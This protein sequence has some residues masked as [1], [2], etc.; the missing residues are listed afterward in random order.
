VDGV[1]RMS[2]G[3]SAVA[4]RIAATNADGDD[5]PEIV[6]SGVTVVMDG[7]EDVRGLGR[8]PCAYGGDDM[9]AGWSVR[10]RGILRD[11]KLIADEVTVTSRTERRARPSRIRGWGYVSASAPGHVVVNGLDVATSR[12]PAKR[13]RAA[14]FAP[15]QRVSVTARQLRDGRLVA[16]RIARR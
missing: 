5:G 7:H 1:Y 13:S 9:R 15:G 6:V 11:G 4:G 8:D 14:A 16:T 2:G 12:S 10:A 3:G